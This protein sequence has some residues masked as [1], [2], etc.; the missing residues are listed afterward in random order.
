MIRK[1][2]T[3]DTR[4]AVLDQPASLTTI[5]RQSLKDVAVHRFQEAIENNEL[6]PGQQ[7]TELGLAASFGVGQA[8]V[9]EALIELEHQG[10]IERLGPRKTCVTLLTRQR[11]DDTYVV[12]RRLEALVVELLIDMDPSVLETP[13][14]KYAELLRAAK[15]ADSV[16]FFR[17]DLAFHRALW[18]ATGNACLADALEI[19]VPK[20]FAFGIIRHFRPDRGKL[21]EMAEVHGRLLD[22]IEARKREAAARV[23]EQSMTVAWSDDQALS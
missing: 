16:G 4:T 1:T 7:I 22:L 10:F 15:A 13:R 19:A 9:R 14:K 2:Q 6:T 18:Q 21:V 20:L 3:Q 17:A 12:R 11:I 5:S 23:A 8:T